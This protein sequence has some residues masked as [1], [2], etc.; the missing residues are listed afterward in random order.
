MEELQ[1]TIQ[2]KVSKETFIIKILTPGQIIEIESLKSQY[3]DGQYSRMS[4]TNTLLSNSAL[5]YVD[6]VATF[7]VLIP[8]L[9][10]SLR[11]KS[12][13][14]LPLDVMEELVSEYRKF[15][16]WWVS[17]INQMKSKETPAA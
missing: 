3:T 4:Q 13:F 1:K 17:W 7:S 10:T 2:I 11:V 5:D 8:E 16:K 6:V 14:D 9:K 15:I 12:L